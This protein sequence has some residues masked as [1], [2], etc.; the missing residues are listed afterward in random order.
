VNFY[1]EIFVKSK[2]LRVLDWEKGK[3]FWKWKKTVG[4]SLFKKVF[5]NQS[6]IKLKL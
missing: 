6:K 2:N 1:Q 4:K 5:K 3:V